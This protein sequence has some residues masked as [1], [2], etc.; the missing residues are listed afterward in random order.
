MSDPFARLSELAPHVDHGRAR[1]RF[2]RRRNLLRRRRRL[3]IGAAAGTI[4]LSGAIG[5]MVAREPDPGTE[6]TA[7]DVADRAGG[8]NED[9]VMPPVPSGDEP[10]QSPRDAA[11]DGVHPEIARLSSSDRTRWLV[12]LPVPE[13]YWAIS[14]PLDETV[15]V[16]DPT[17]QYGIERVVLPEYAEILLVDDEGR[18]QRAYPMPGLVPSWLHVT[19]KYVYAGRVGDGALPASSVVRIDR[20]DSTAQVIVF[21]VEGH[22]AIT[23]LGW[24]T[25]PEGASIDQLVTVGPPGGAVAS[26]IGPVNVDTDAIDRLMNRDTWGPLTVVDGAPS[27]RLARITGTL[28]MDENCVTLTATDGQQVLLVWPSQATAWDADEGAVIYSPN[29]ESVT[30]TDGQTVSFGG[31][32][33]GS[34]SQVEYVSAS[35]PSC[36]ASDAWLVGG[37]G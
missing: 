7:T 4:V 28:R 2:D 24:R 32:S 31:A 1:Q 35:H 13:G 15:E 14:Q 29:D 10:S 18:I 9:Q 23:D 30:L 16:G 25:A 20:R 22:Q 21:P 36:P 3:V 8:T 27:G 6:V 12:S 37:L 26:W 19:A 17:G 11:R 34:D 5:A 33:A